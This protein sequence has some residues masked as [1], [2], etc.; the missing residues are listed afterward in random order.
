MAPPVVTIVIV[1]H[2]VRGELERCFASIE[3]YAEM[4][5]EVILVDNAST[6]GTLEWT[7]REHPR[8][9]VVALPDNIGVA[10]RDHGLRRAGGR[11]T[12]FLDSD[13]ALTPGALPAMVAALEEH[14]DWGLV[15]PRL[16]YEN[17]ALQL[18]C[19]RFPP[20][21]LP[22]MRRPPLDRLFENGRTVRRHLMADIDHERAR[23]VVYVLGACQ[24]F[25]TALARIAGPFDD[26]VFLGWDDADWCIRIRDAG[27]EIVYLPEAKVVHSYRRLTRRRPVSRAGWR[28]LGAFL[29]F[30]RSYAR[31]RRQLIRLGEELDQRAMGH[32]QSRSQSQGV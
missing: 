20:L 29:H 28:Q 10:A 5:V 24:L 21:F 9:T 2:S 27:G 15:G 3:A 7:E 13:A 16:V 22:L 1:A 4:A 19:R 25:R 26:R 8:V 23:P 14:P 31:R 17:G 12:M 18:S 6:D 30:Q 32:W 11:Y